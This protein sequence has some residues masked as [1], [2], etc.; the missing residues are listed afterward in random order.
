MNTLYLDTS[1]NYLHIALFDNDKLTD[2]LSLKLDK[3]LSKYTLSNLEKIL[4]I[5]N[6]SINDINKIIV[7]NGPGSFTGV[8]IGLTI[9]KTIGWAKKVDI[10][11]LSSLK[12]MIFSVTCKK[13]YI[14]PIID[15]RRGYVYAAIYDIEQK[16]YI[17]NEGYISL[18]ALLVSIKSLKLIDDNI[19]DIL[20]VSNDDICINYKQQKYIPNF[21]QIIKNTKEEKV[22]N[23]HVIDANYLK[24]TE[25]EEKMHD[26]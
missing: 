20:I 10:V 16:N 24:L 11:P 13:K 1:S 5:N 17:L 25:A 7:V 6:I 12:P 26:C 4:K 2:K 21:E 9:A 23:P 22:I 15:A 19:D 14:V 8:R 18:N 3:D